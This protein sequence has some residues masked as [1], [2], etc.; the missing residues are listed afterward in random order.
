MPVRLRRL[1]GGVPETLKDRREIIL[2]A[3]HS[4]SEVLG[5]CLFFFC[6]IAARMHLK[7]PRRM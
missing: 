2:R 7:H 1:S 3:H 5:R 4:T 6:Y